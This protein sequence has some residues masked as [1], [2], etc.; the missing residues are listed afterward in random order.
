MKKLVIVYVV[1]IVAV[2]LLALV[3]GGDLLNF[4]PSIGGSKATAKVNDK[5]VNLILAKSDNDRTRGLSGRDSLP[6]DQGML[7]IF[8][9][10]GI[11]GFWMR[12]MKFPIDIIFLSDNKVVHVVENATPAGQVPSLTIYQPDEPAN[13]VLELNAGKAGEMGIK[14]GATITFEGI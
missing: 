14:E 5:T 7:F 4:I 6:E 2:I 13:F 9:K 12:D 10:K 3:R 11:Y 1:L 8:D